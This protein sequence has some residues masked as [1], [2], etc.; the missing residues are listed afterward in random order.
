MSK[1]G[2]TSAAAG[3]AEARSRKMMEENTFMAGEKRWFLLVEVGWLLVLWERRDG[4][5]SKQGIAGL[6]KT[7]FASVKCHGYFPASEE[8]P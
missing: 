4:V 3:T 8:R 7:L 5:N 2:M 6:L 1:R